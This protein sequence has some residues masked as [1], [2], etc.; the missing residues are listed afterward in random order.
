MDL[1]V[2]VVLCRTLLKYPDLLV[3]LISLLVAIILGICQMRQANRVEAFERRLEDRDEKRYKDLVYSQ[4][5]QF[6]QKY[7]VGGQE[8]EIHL[9]SLCIAA[10]KY[11][12]VYPYRREIY[13]EFCGLTEDVRAAILQRCEIDIPCTR[14]DN[15]YVRCL[16]DLLED[17]KIYCPEDRDI[18]YDGGKYLERGLLNHGPEP[19]TDIRCAVDEWEDNVNKLY[20]RLGGTP[21]PD[22]SYK[23]HVLNVLD[24]ANTK[25]PINALWL[26]DTSLGRPCDS[27]EILTC[28]LCCIIAQ[29][30]PSYLH[31]AN[32]QYNTGLLGDYVGVRYME[33]EFLEALSNVTV[34]G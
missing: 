4:A 5:T 17:I 31:R 16:R 13:R 6:I 3:A 18:F 28:Y 8:A 22:M 9:L 20:K 29:Y 10:Y 24:R 1:C 14:S 11:N 26:E 23:R 30:V 32:E 12:L 34:Y 33:D 2:I 15:Y 27:D 7:S 19:V 21:S 25:Q